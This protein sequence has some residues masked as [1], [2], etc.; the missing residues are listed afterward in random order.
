VRRL[1]LLLLATHTLWAASIR[2]PAFSTDVDEQSCVARKPAA[3]F[4]PSDRQVFFSFIAR[5]VAAG[6][7][8]R[9]EWVNPAGSIADF[10]DYPALPPAPALCFVTQ[11]PVSGFPASSQPGAWSVRVIVNDR[12]LGRYGFEMAQDR[13]PDR[14]RVGQVSRRRLSASET[15]LVLDGA[16]F[17]GR[18][19]VHIAEY[20][21][22]GGWRYIH[23]VLAGAATTNRLTVRVPALV[24]GEYL[25]IVKNSDDAISQPARFLVSAGGGYHLPIAS[26]ERW[27][28]TQG[29]Y[30]SFSHWRNSLHAYDIAPLSGKWVVAMRAGVVYT[31]DVGARQSHTRRTFGNYITIQHEE[32][33]FSQI[34]RAHV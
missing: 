16:G 24:P 34:G 6:D 20:T 22:S 18:S 13:N 21:R 19:I 11:L 12:E 26:G 31:H 3:G 5:E 27:V 23:S 29:P 1:S 14:V 9:L 25:A 4:H 7:R 15:E 2:T 10:A 30:G 33:E 17:D 28:I 32:G 8:L